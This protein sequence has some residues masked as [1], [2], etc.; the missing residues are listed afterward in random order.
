[1]Q[2]THSLRR[3]TPEDQPFL[4]EL[5][6]ATRQEELDA[7]GLSGP[8]RETFLRQQFHAMT[9]GYAQTFADADRWIIERSG[10]PVGRL[11]VSRV[12]DEHRVVDLA[13]LPGHRGL[14]IGGEILRRI[15]RDAA[16]AGMPVRLQVFEDNRARQLYRRL[17]FIET[18]SNGM[19]VQM[20]WRPDSR[21]S[22]P[23]SCPEG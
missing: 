20:E 2:A 19:R 1:M 23:G 5:Y 11:L 4:F 16:A 10:R 15:Q 17:G 12:G 22:A 7:A 8:F 3:E 13:V 14:G 9:V 18:G 6:G 21:P